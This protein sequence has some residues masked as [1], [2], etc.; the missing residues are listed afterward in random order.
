MSSSPNPS[1]MTLRSQCRTGTSSTS[2]DYRSLLLV[3]TALM[4]IMFSCTFYYFNSRIKML[5]ENCQSY[6]SITRDVVHLINYKLNIYDADK[7]NKP[8]YALESSGASIVTSRCTKTYLEKNIQY[9][10]DGILP[11]LFTSNSPRVVIQP[12]MIPGECWSFAGSQGVMVVQLS[13]T[14]VP[15]SFTYEHIRRE[16]HPDLNIDSA[17]KSIRVFGLNDANDE[18]GQLLGEYEYDKEGSSLQEFKVQ[19]PSP[20]LT[21][22]IQ[23]VVQ[24]NHGESQYTCLYRFRVH[25]TKYE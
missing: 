21:K 17:P 24:S 18:D 6:S 14:I 22:Y 10:I 25:G 23:L 5:E 7:T 13:R 8:D 15:T 1:P 3:V 12:S 4:T 20:M 16:I 9:S 19:N 2:S 11:I